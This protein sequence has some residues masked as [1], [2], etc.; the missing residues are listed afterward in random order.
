MLS[1][2]TMLEP[3]LWSTWDILLVEQKEMSLNPRTVLGT[4]STSGLLGGG[5]GST[6][7]NL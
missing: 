1:E 5:R 7:E 6:P 2:G 3:C 4:Q